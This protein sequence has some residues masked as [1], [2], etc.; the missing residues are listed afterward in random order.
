MSEELWKF[1]SES[2]SWQLVSNQGPSARA[3]H[4]AVW[5]PGLQAIWVHGGFDGQALR[6]LWRFETSNGLWQLVDVQGPAARFSHVGV[7]DVATRSLWLHGGRTPQLVVLADFWQYQAAELIVTTTTTSHTA[8]ATWSSTSETTSLTGTSLSS[9]GT[10]LSS[11]ATSWTTWTTQ[12]VSS[13]TLTSATATSTSMV[14]PVQL[15]GPESSTSAALDL[16]YVAIILGILCLAG[17][18]ALTC[19]LRGR[20][21]IL[22]EAPEPAASPPQCPPL[23][24]TITI[25]PSAPEPRV[26]A[27]VKPLSEILARVPLPR[28]QRHP[29][30]YTEPPWPLY[31]GPGSSVEPLYGPGR[32]AYW[33][34]VRPTHQ[35][36][37]PDLGGFRMMSVE[38]LYESLQD[39]MQ[40]G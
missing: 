40:V 5:D 23:P 3:F 30:V 15:G 8:T 14:L 7:W 19:W 38:F 1:D 27:R 6:D 24:I 37:G 28:E 36:Q 16:V 11:T 29:E 2:Y 34:P 9:T 32:L 12:T 39:G 18:V 25:A 20:K 17:L 33:S 13:E 35:L 10:S 22:P 4:V 31:V 26:E 21:A